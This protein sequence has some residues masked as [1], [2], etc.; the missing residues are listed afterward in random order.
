[1]KTS[2]YIVLS[3]LVI[4][5]LVLLWVQSKFIQHSSDWYSVIGNLAS[6]LLVCGVISFLQEIII[7]KETDSKMAEM[8]SIST[9][10]K[11]SGLRNILTNSNVFIYTT[12]LNES[13]V[14]YAI[15]NDGLRWTETNSAALTDRFNKKNTITEFFLVDP[16]GAFLPALAKKTEKT[17]D[18]LK[19]KI[20]QSISTLKS[21]YDKSEKK[22]TIRIYLLKNYPTQSIFYTDRSVI[23]TT[24]QTSCGRNTVPLYEYKYR[25]DE[26][27]IAK[28]LYK[29]LDN[30]RLESKKILDSDNV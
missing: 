2:N 20:R 10:V 14:F 25:K 8:F 29:D 1:M 11:E 6:A 23:V 9:S 3:I 22:G 19:T 17:E 13:N 24:Y 18:E 21:I 4:V 16:D 27:N 12:L 26:T 15:L 7:R 28:Y 5:S 30:V